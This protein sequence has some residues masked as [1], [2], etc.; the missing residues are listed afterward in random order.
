MWKWGG[1]TAQGS[2]VYVLERPVHPASVY[3]PGHPALEIDLNKARGFEAGDLIPADASSIYTRFWTNEQLVNGLWGYPDDSLPGVTYG[4]VAFYAYNYPYMLSANPFGDFNDYGQW[5]MV[6]LFAVRDSN[7]LLYAFWINDMPWDDSAGSI[8][9]RVRGTGALAS[10]LYNED[11]LLLLENDAFGKDDYQYYRGNGLFSWRWLACCTTGVVMGPLPMRELQP[12]AINWQ[13][14]SKQAGGDANN[15]NSA[16]VQGI[17]I[18][19]WAN[20]T[21]E[22]SNMRLVHY[23]V[24]LPYASDAS[25]DAAV[26]A[27]S[28]LVVLGGSVSCANFGT[29]A[30]TQFVEDVASW[31]GVDPDSADVGITVDCATSPISVHV[32]ITQH[33]LTASAEVNKL[34]LL[35]SLNNAGTKTKPLSFIVERVCGLF[36]RTH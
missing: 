14:L 16:L 3:P 5:N 9:V 10:S 31:V 25:Y 23:D 4:A 35:F 19:Q 8:D 6:S 20:P 33:A 17:R 1:E 36:S 7:A 29:A 22:L 2:G 12:F 27:I 13:M 28:Q 34:A 21:G 15:P 11:S 30:R 32:R 26:Y 24:P 18:Y